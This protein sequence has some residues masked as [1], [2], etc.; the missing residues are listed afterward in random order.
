LRRHGIEYGNW[1]TTLPVPE[2]CELV[3]LL[4]SRRLVDIE[5]ARAI[6]LRKIPWEVGDLQHLAPVKVH[7]IDLSGA[8]SEKHC[9]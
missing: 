7:P 2:H 9:R 3:T 1:T 5:A 4:A 6:T 8:N